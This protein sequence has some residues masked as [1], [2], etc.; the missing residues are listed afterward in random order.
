MVRDVRYG[1]LYEVP[2]HLQSVLPGI[3]RVDRD[4]FGGGEDPGEKV[5][6]VVLGVIGVIL[7]ILLTLL[8]IEKRKNWKKDEK[9]LQQKQQIDHQKKQAEVHKINQEISAEASEAIETIKEQQEEVDYKIEEADTDEEI[10][11]IA[12]DI[13]SR[14]NNK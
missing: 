3:G 2:A 8:G 10:I 13:V 1:L 6:D 12:N 5:M 9:I 7:T 4:Q 14:F 11:A